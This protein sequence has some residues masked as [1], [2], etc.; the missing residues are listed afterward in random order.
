MKLYIKQKLFS[1]KDRFTIKDEHQN[2]VL[3]VEGKLFS[4]GKQ[5]SVST[6]DMQEVAFVKQKV[7]NFLPTFEIS[8]Q[9]Q[10]HTLKKQFSF[11]K[12]VYQI[13]SLGLRIE[14]NFTAHHY[15][16]YKEGDVL[17][18]ISKAFFSFA[19]SYEVDI[20]NDQDRDMVIAV[21]LAID[22]VLDMER[23]S[24]VNVSTNNR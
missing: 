16:I 9:D 14:G 18:N 6:M 12:P 20:L 17:A 2:D 4:F 10:V 8:L 22:A 21:V 13:P 5:L 24:S 7:F 11:F 19:D 1:F 3:Q 15:S 23:S